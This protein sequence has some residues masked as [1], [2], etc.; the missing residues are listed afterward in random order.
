ML[1][2]LVVID[3]IDRFCSRQYTQP[4][5][6]P[7]IVNSSF[8]EIIELEIEILDTKPRKTI[9]SENNSPRPSYKSA[10]RTKTTRGQ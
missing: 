8:F 2:L 3:V 6:C 5:L 9:V 7:D 10:V 1:A 4:E